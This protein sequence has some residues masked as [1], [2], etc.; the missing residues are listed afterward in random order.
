LGHRDPRSFAIRAMK[1]LVDDAVPADP[2]RWAQTVAL[3]S[4]SSMCRSGRS[5]PACQSSW[6]LATS[7][8]PW[9]VYLGSR[10]GPSK[11]GC[12]C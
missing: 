11:I 4:C 2:A 7:R 9:R 10:S 6:L 5:V 3:A 8:A 12:I 1:K